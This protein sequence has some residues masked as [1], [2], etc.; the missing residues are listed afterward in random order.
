MRSYVH[1]ANGSQ[2]QQQRNSHFLLTIRYVDGWTFTLLPP[3]YL[4][5]R[6]SHSTLPAFELFGRLVYAGRRC[7]LCSFS[8]LL[9]LSPSLFLSLSPSLLHAWARH[10]LSSPFYSNRERASSNS[11]K[12]CTLIRK[13]CANAEDKWLFSGC[14]RQTR[15]DPARSSRNSHI[16]KHARNHGCAAE[17]NCQQTSTWKRLWKN[18]KKLLFRNVCAVREQQSKA[19]Y[20]IK[21]TSR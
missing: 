7:F 6:S 20:L 12:H 10:S 2:Q 1:F 18:P 5:I 3:L 4:D 13:I 9:S 21:S 15:S 19:A 8:C 11:Y 17:R 14:D 16:Q